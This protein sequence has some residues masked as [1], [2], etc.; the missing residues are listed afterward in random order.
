MIQ[1][2]RFLMCAAAVLATIGFTHSTSAFDSDGDEASEHNGSHN[3]GSEHSSSSSSG[4]TDSGSSGSESS[5]S[6]S[7]GTSSNGRTTNDDLRRPSSSR[8]DLHGN[9][10]A[11]ATSK[12]ASSKRAPSKPVTPTRNRPTTRATSSLNTATS[13]TASSRDDG[14]ERNAT[15]QST[16]GGR[17]KAEYK[18]S[19]TNRAFEIEL[20]NT[21]LTPGQ[22]LSVAVNNIPVGMMTVRVSERRATA[23]MN[24]DSRHGDSVPLNSTGSVI[25]I[26]AGTTTV[27]TG[28]F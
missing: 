6:S 15:L 18:V 22:T 14:S 24:L 23:K 16:V 10:T 12:R 17:G 27:A 7:A 11:R 8:S 4:S 13:R 19:G 25:T 21:T 26:T 20:K 9:S 28:T 1:F 3:E 5:K 2:R